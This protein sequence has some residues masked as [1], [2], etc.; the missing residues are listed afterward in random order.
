MPQTLK[1]GA[2]AIIGFILLGA[3]REIILATEKI[4]LTD[5]SLEL[6]KFFVS[7]QKIDFS[8]L[9]SIEYKY[10]RDYLS[11]VKIIRHG[12]KNVYLTLDYL[13]DKEAFKEEL[14]KRWK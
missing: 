10:D 7:D 9:S 12:A 2:Y 14:E 11:G 5:T 4:A 8:T 6:H 13:K 3:I 1:W